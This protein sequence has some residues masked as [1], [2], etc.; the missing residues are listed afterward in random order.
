MQRADDPPL[1]APD[2]PRFFRRYDGV[3]WEDVPELQRPVPSNITETGDSPVRVSFRIAWAGRCGV[4]LLSLSNSAIIRSG[5]T[6]GLMSLVL[7]ILPRSSRLFWNGAPV[8]N[9]HVINTAGAP[10]SWSLQG[11]CTLLALTVS[12]SD[13]AAGS[14]SEDEYS[15]YLRDDVHVLPDRQ[16]RHL[17]EFAKRTLVLAERDP[18][19]ETSIDVRVMHAGLSILVFDALSAFKGVP[20][21]LGFQAQQRQRFRE[22][23]ALFDQDVQ[24]LDDLSKRLAVSKRT[25]NYVCKEFFGLAPIEVLR[26]W[27]LYAVR[28]TLRQNRDRRD[29]VWKI[30][31][32]FGFW[33][34]GRFSAM[35]KQQFGESPSQTLRN[36]D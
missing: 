22:L 3:R 16:R 4:A 8:G 18:D 14:A 25:L 29:A 28:R 27:R 7:P 13:P 9:G 20:R 36:T 23:L 6:V 11:S 31:A 2:G 33:H 19:W 12:A 21:P 32:D 26:L 10:I 30:A 35:Y 15:S 34:P 17:S 24:S 1:S 5:P